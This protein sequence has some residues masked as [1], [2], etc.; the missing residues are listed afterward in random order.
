MKLNFNLIGSRNKNIR[1]FII[2]FYNDKF[3]TYHRW[4]CWKR[5]TKF[6][7]NSSSDLVTLSN[8]EMIF[9]SNYFYLKILSR[10]GV[11]IHSS[12]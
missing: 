10:S 12:I 9:F 6:L 2:P 4:L 11:T 8:Y 1:F 3:I 5:I 7:K